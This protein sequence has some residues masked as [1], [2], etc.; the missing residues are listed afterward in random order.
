MAV[1]VSFIRVASNSRDPIT[2]VSEVRKTEIVAV[3]GATSTVANDGEIAVVTNFH[4]LPIRIAFGAIPDA[5][6]ADRSADSSAGYLLTFEQS[7]TL[8]LRSGDKIN[9]KAL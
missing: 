3:P 2:G 5:A 8:H 1:Y 6:L 9:V 4:G 7:L